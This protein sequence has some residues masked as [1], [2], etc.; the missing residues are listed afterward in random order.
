[1]QAYSAIVEVYD[2]LGNLV[3][4]LKHIEDGEYRVEFE[5]FIS[6]DQVR[7]VAKVMDSH[8]CTLEIRDDS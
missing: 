2:D 1:M 6:A 4:T 8:L 7:F 3:A 5:E